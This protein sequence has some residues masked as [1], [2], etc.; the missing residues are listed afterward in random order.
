MRCERHTP[1][2]P[3]MV[4]AAAELADIASRDVALGGVLAGSRREEKGAR[5]SKRLR[6]HEK[7]GPAVR[8]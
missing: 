2:P 7:D 4:A 6:D 3:V 5:G 8:F 1:F